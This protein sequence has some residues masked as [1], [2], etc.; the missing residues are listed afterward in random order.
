MLR[1]AAAA[2]RDRAARRWSSAEATCPA[3]ALMV[4]GWEL[5]AANLESLADGIASGALPVDDALR[6][7]RGTSEAR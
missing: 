2:H 3:D 4:F 5:K 1:S 7:A 6:T